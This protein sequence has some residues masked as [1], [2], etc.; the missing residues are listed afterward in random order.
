M[1]VLDNIPLNTKQQFVA[2]KTRSGCEVYLPVD[3][4]E[5]DELIEKRD[6]LQ[7]HLNNQPYPLISPA[8]A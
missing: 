3:S 5:R 2:A 1:S 4:F 6:E 7:Q 8:L